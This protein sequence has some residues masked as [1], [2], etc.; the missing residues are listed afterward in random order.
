MLHRVALVETD[1]SEEGI[2]S[3]IRVTKIYEVGTT[4][5][6]YEELMFMLEL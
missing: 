5:P 6:R 1:V 2:A 3:V 4:E